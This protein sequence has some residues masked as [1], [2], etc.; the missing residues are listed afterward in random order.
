MFL[1]VLAL[2]SITINAAIAM[3][4]VSLRLGD[5]PPETR[6][7]FGGSSDISK[8]KYNTMDEFVFHIIHNIVC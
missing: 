5:R 8:G 6:A 2:G 7:F 3:V 1:F 4:D